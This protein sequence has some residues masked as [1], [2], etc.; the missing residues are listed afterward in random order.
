MMPR[1]VDKSRNEHI[2]V[3]G[4]F[5]DKGNEVQRGFPRVISDT[6]PEIP[7]EVSGR[8]ELARWLPGRSI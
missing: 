8:R 1:D 5:N 7:P 3:A 4:H 2:R 6:H